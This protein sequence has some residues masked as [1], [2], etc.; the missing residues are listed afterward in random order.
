MTLPTL[1]GADYCLTSKW[2]TV[3]VFFFAKLTSMYAKCVKS[4]ERVKQDPKK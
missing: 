1:K 3:N 2:M 4:G